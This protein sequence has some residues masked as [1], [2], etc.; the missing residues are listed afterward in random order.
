MRQKDERRVRLIGPLTGLHKHAQTVSTEL[1]WVGG[2]EPSSGAL[3]VAV[4]S[5]VSRLLRI[6]SSL[7]R[8]SS[9]ADMRCFRCSSKSISADL[10]LHNLH[11]SAGLR[12]LRVLNRPIQHT[13][14]LRLLPPASGSQVTPLSQKKLRGNVGMRLLGNI[15]VS[16]ARRTFSNSYLIYL[17]TRSKQRLAALLI[18]MSI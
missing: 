2:R 5:L 4:A 18:S 15:Q 12:W 17:R 14:R 6:S 13:R 10:T 7:L 3:A 8:F 9:S 11:W 1:R 16:V